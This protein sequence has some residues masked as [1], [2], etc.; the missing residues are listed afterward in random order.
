[1]GARA[2]IGVRWF[3]GPRR[4]PT[5]TLRE[6]QKRVFAEFIEIKNGDWY[7]GLT[8]YMDWLKMEVAK[9]FMIDFK[10]EKG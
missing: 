4:R 3:G 8:A 7:D 2:L 5:L 9:A 10:V 1:M 6:H